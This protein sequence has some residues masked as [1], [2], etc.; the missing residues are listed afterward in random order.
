MP[1]SSLQAALIKLKEEEL[2]MKSSK[3]PQIAALVDAF[4]ASRN[5]EVTNFSETIAGQ[6]QSCVKAKAGK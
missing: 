1:F 5:A 2:V 3:G 4:L 6:I